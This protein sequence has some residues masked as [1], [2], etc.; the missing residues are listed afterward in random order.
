MDPIARKQL[1]IRLAL[2]QNPLTAFKMNA[3]RNLAMAHLA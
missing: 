1:A 3:R 2:Q